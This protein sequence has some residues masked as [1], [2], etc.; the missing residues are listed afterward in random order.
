MNH[1]SMKSILIMLTV[2]TILGPRAPSVRAGKPAHLPVWGQQYE[3]HINYIEIN[4][5]RFELAS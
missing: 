5:T 2:L 4:G 3:D 1:E